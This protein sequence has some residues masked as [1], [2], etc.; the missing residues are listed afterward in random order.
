MESDSVKNRVKADLAQ[1]VSVG[2]KGTPHFFM[3]GNVINGAQPL[4]NFQKSL[5]REL[6]IADKYIKRGVAADALYKTIYLE[7]SK[8]NAP[9]VA[10]PLRDV[11]PPAQVAPSEPIV[12]TQGKS[13]AKGPENAPVVIYQFS[14]FQCP[15]CAK[16]E[17][18][19]K[20]VE[21]AYGDKVRIIF[22]NRPLSF[23][24]DARLASEA[25]LAA[26]AQGK[27]WEMHQILFANQK[28]L[29]REALIEYAKQLELDIDKFTADLDNHTFAAQI[30]AEIADAEK[31]GA[32]GT[33]T[34]VINGKKF[35]GAQPFDKFKEQIDAAL[36]A[37]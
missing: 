4:Q 33:P 6:A 1:G 13:Y 26:G 27:F 22:K 32:T 28:S 18:T 2:V 12:L 35:V 10:R 3:N 7:E 21:E 11:R 34:F 36:A 23:H 16:V 17:P 24:A 8:N 37:K 19:I 30:D 9:A 14:E 31:A 29:K 15:F 5:D 25:A 20:Q